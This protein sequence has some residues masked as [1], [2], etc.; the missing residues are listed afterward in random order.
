MYD[1]NQDLDEVSVAFAS[2]TVTASVTGLTFTAQACDLPGGQQ[3]VTVLATDLQGLSDSETVTISIDAGVTTT[4]TEHINAGRLDYT[5]YA[6]CYLEYADA[7]FKLTEQ[8]QAG[9]MCVWQDDDASCTGPAQA[10][11]GSA[12][13][14][15]SGGDNGGGEPPATCAEFTTANYYHKVA[16]RAYSTGY[17]Y[18]PDY[19]AV[20]SDDPLAGS[21]WGTSTLHST[22]NVIWYAGSCP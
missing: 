12:G 22:D 9:G 5:A 20:G 3:T 21:T 2:Q 6:T 17:Y 8:T 16:G 15:G 4:L 7:A 14:G 19:F 1:E 10:C 18:A 11:S 13:D